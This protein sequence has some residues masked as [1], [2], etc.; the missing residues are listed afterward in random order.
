MIDRLAEEI[1]PDLP[2]NGM[3][4]AVRAFIETCDV[5]LDWLFSEAVDPSGDAS[6]ICRGSTLALPGDVGTWV[7]SV[8][9]NEPS[10]QRVTRMLFAM[11][12]D[13]PVE[14][15]D[16]A[17]ALNEVVNVA[18]GVFKKY[19]DALGE[20]LDIGLPTYLDGNEAASLLSD[21]LHGKS[22]TINTDDGVSLKIIAFWHEGVES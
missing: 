1:S 4:D 11:E 2:E 18:A 8:V 13:E 3:D 5:Q 12:E 10:S 21:S 20:H 15:E 16:A 19:R 9:C 6:D 17:D 14:L 7:L 22:R